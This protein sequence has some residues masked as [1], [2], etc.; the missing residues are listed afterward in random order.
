VSGVDDDGEGDEARRRD[1]KP[2]C[3]VL[4]RDDVVRGPDKGFGRWYGPFPPAARPAK[5]PSWIPDS[6]FREIHRR[7]RPGS[8]VRCNRLSDAISN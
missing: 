4:H 5:P 1:E 2:A 7:R 3:L 8:T 6:G